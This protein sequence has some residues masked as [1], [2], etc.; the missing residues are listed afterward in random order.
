M[1]VQ[2]IRRHLATLLGATLL[3]AMLV[4]AVARPAAA[5]DGATFTMAANARR[6]EAGVGPVALHATINQIAVERSNEVAAARQIGHDFPALIE[7]FA[8]LGVC[9]QAL[10]E[11]VAM[12]SSGTV[13][14]FITQWMNST[15]HRSVML[16]GNY[17]HVG[18]SSTVGSD[19]RH[20]GVMVFARVCGETPAPPQVLGPGGFYDTHTSAFGGDIAWLVQAGI[21]TGCATGYFCPTSPVTREQMASF[22]K[23]ATNLPPAGF[24]FFVDD[25]TSIHEGDINGIA[26]AGITMGC[27]TAR[28]CPQA[29]VS[30]EQMATFLARALGLPPA[31]TDYFV[32][33]T[34]SVHEGDINRLAAAGVTSGCGGGRYCPGASI[35]REQMAAFLHR[36]FD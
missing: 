27:A 7:R 21:T 3:A 8:Q 13:D 5:V 30:R 34:G 19:G 29:N 6:A 35:T 32:D 17:T 11:I 22:L 33:D 12:N 23:R 26:T 25:A 31:T 14:T 10:G 1:P 24:D 18:G 20:Y 16:N 36:A 15:V 2:S 28:Y 9:W 4:P